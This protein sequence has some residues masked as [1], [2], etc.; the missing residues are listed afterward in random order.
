[1]L[2]ASADASAPTIDER[3][4]VSAREES[5]RLSMTFGDARPSTSRRARRIPRSVA[6]AEAR[7]QH[8]EV[9]IDQE[10]RIADRQLVAGLQRGSPVDATRR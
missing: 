1:M 4:R 8:G 2:A 6:L 7:G 9:G 3:R 5:R 10:Q